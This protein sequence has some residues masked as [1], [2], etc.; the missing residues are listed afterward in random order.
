ME[1]CSPA[2]GY[3]GIDTPCNVSLLAHVLTD[4]Q[5]PYLPN[6]Y[7]RDPFSLPKA[8]QSS[9]LF[10]LLNVDIIRNTILGW[11]LRDH[12]DGANFAISCRTAFFLLAGQ[13]V[14]TGSILI[15]TLS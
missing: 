15:R 6:Y 8:E 14:S 9:K 13:I 3:L 4:I 11:V 5:G 12:F 2:A 10:N 7:H 1:E